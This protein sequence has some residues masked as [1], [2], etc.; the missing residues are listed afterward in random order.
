[1]VTGNLGN[2]PLCGY[3]PPAHLRDET[4][5]PRCGI[6]YA[7]Y[8]PEAHKAPRKRSTTE[9]TGG[10]RDYPLPFLALL[11]VVTLL[12]VYGLATSWGVGD[13]VN[14]PPSLSSLATAAHVHCKGFVRGRL[15]SPANTDFPTLDYEAGHRNGL[16]QIKSYVDTPNLFG[17]VTREHYTCETRYTGGS[18]GSPSSWELSSLRMGG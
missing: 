6:I 3:M 14:E 17:A 13:S 18:P 4:D 5:C 16:F 8:R 10:L 1:M 12:V 7:N 2:C 9:P 15:G 11:C